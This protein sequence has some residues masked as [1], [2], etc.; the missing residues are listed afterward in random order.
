MSD[1]PRWREIYKKVLSILMAVIQKNFDPE[2]VTDK[3]RI[4]LDLGAEPKEVEQIPIEYEKAFGIEITEAEYDRFYETVG[5]H[6]DY[7]CR[8]EDLK[9]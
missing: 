5:G 6:V 8:R 2:K 1:D 4:I 3:T 7:L 9:I